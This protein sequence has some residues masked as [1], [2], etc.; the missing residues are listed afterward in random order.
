[1]YTMLLFYNRQHIL[2]TGTGIGRRMAAAAAAAAVERPGTYV[3]S[4]G[5]RLLLFS[6]NKTY[7]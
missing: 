3:F 1:M 4:A 5:A 7:V 2:S 6:Y